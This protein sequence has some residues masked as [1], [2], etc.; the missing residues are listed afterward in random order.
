MIPSNDKHKKY[1]NNNNNNIINTISQTDITN[2]QNLYTRPSLYL[3][4]TIK[5]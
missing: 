4:T 2:D 5:N 1:N 3:H